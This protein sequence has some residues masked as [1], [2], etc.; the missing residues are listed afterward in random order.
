MKT[1]FDIR[2]AVWYK[3]DIDTF[4]G[5]SLWLWTFSLEIVVFYF[6][7]IFQGKVL[8]SV[9]FSFSK[10]WVSS[11]NLAEGA[12]QISIFTSKQITETVK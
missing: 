9:T 10:D 11:S 8:S 3:F 2:I 6:W 5:R 4:L 7:I 12:E 1:S